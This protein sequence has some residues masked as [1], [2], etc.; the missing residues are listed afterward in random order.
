MKRKTHTTFAAIHLGSEKVYDSKIMTADYL[1]WSIDEAFRTW[2]QGKWARHLSFDE[3]CEFL[4]PYKVVET[5]LL[6]DW[7][8]R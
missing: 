3:F 4:L 7:R 5:Q 1:I 2:K 8:T 6:D